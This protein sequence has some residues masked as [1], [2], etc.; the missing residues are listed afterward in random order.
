[1]NIGVGLPTTTPGADGALVVEWA[2]RA[3]AG[4]FTSLAVLDRLAY[5]SFE[6]FT[7]LAAAAGPRWPERRGVSAR[8]ISPHSSHWAN[9]RLAARWL[10]PSARRTSGSESGPSE[11]R[12]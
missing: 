10:M 6:P 7:A 2:K 3:E 1:M 12:R 4:P 9:A 8:S 11:T 5:E